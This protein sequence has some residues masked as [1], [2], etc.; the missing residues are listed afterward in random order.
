MKMAAGL[1]VEGIGN[2]SR[3]EGI[4]DLVDLTADFAREHGWQ[5]KLSQGKKR[6]GDGRPFRFAQPGSRS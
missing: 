3:P 5:R 2:V 4:P 1:A 6:C